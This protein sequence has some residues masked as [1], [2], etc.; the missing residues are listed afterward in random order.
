MLADS[1]APGP[2]Q[3]RLGWHFSTSRAHATASLQ[4]GAHPST[5]LDRIA[6]PTRAQEHRISFDKLKLRDS[7][8]GATEKC[9]HMHARRHRS[10][11]APP[12]VGAWSGC[13]LLPYMHSG[14]RTWSFPHLLG[15][16]P[17]ASRLHQR[18]KGSAA[19][20]NCLRAC[21]KS[22]AAGASRPARRPSC[23]NARAARLGRRGEGCWM[24]RW[25]SRG[26]RPP[27]AVDAP[28]C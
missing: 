22:A 12:A 5:G 15:R 1:R 16:A 10:A 11:S 4:A 8:P 9:T 3:E 21:G 7:I 14:R 20:A 24:L 19:A 26:G 17:R 2:C 25:A 18:A 28:G 6:T 13:R 23:L 27:A